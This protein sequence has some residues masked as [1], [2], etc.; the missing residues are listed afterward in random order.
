MLEVLHNHKIHSISSVGLIVE[1]MIIMVLC[2]GNML[3]SVCIYVFKLGWVAETASKYN[4]IKADSYLHLHFY[5]RL[6]AGNI[7]IMLQP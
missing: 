1:G 6:H 4:R 7:R 2:W 3:R 5:L